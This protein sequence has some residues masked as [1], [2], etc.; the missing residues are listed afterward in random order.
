MNKILKKSAEKPMYNPLAFEKADVI[1]LTKCDL[2]EFVDFDDE[3]FMK[4]VRALNKRAQV[5]EVNGK[6][7]R[8]F[9]KVAEC[10]KNFQSEG[11]DA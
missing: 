11:N 1:I 9:E 3:F 8:G 6:T 5:F 4:G 7:G 2:K 10:L